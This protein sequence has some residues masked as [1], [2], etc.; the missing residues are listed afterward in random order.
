MVNFMKVV[1]DGVRL[2]PQ[3]SICLGSRLLL[4]KPDALMC[5]RLVGCSAF[6]TAA[7]AAAR[8]ISYVD[9]YSCVVF[10]SRTATSTRRRC[11][12]ERC[13][14]P[15]LSASS[16]RENSCPAT[17]R[18]ST[19]GEGRRRRRRL[20]QQRRQR[21]PR[22]EAQQQEQS[23]APATSRRRTLV[24]AKEAAVAVL[25]ARALMKERGCWRRWTPLVKFPVRGEGWRSA[26]VLA[27]ST[28]L[29]FVFFR[30]LRAC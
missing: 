17:T 25:A 18:L 30:R 2:L 20:H 15:R 10:V 3:L 1:A 22:D 24:P 19:R 27:S 14:G 13:F 28:F 29:A 23:V 5:S 21:R 9:T 26:V 7:A 4:P 6:V 16:C 12:E 8:P 11:S